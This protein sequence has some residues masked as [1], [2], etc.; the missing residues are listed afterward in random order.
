M[1]TQITLYTK[2]FLLLLAVIQETGC[3]WTQARNEGQQTRAHI[4]GTAQQIAALLAEA[5]KQDLLY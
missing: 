3:Y 2:D 5:L 1:P 4:E